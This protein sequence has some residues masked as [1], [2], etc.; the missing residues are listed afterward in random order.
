M[1]QSTGVITAL[2]PTGRWEAEIGKLS[3][4]LKTSCLMCRA[5]QTQV[6]FRKVGEIQHK[7]VLANLH[8]CTLAPVDPQPP[9]F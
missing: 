8:T 1:Q 9:P 2:L 4:R 3:R 6:L 7:N 5:Q